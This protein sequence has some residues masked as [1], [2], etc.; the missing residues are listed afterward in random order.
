MHGFNDFLVRLDG[1]LG[2]H[3]WFMVLLI[4]TGLFFTFYLGFPQIRYFRHAL[5]ITRGKYDHSHDVGDTSHF[6]SLA[7]ALSGTVGT[8]NI[9]GV[10]LAI[11]LGGPAALFWMLITAAIGMCT[12]MVEVSLSHKYRDI[13]PDGSVSGGPMY[14]MKK[15]LNITT[16]SGKIIRT[17]AILGAFFAG[18]TV[19][20]SFGT[21]SL[22]QINSISNSVFTTFGV[23]HIITGAILAVFLGLV[24]IGGIKRIA[25]VTSVMVPFMAILYL[26]GSLLVIFSHPGNIIPSFVSIFADAFT[27]SAA[28]GGFLGATFAFAMNRGVNRGLFSNESGQGSAPIAHSAARAPEPVSEGMVSLLEPFIDTICICTLTGLVVLASGAWNTKTDNQFQATDMQILT[29]IYDD[30]NSADVE[31][32]S[33][34]L[35]GDQ[36]LDLY[37]GKLTV[38]NGVITTTGISVIHARSLASNIRFMSDKAPFSGELEVLAGKLPNMASMTV[39]GESLIHSAPLTTFAF[40]RSIMKGFGPYIVTLSL[41]L[42]AFSTAISWSYYGDRAVTYL[43][44]PKYVLYYRLIFVVAFFIASFTDTTIIWS[45]SYVAIVLMAVPNLIGILILRKEV[46][47]SV[48]DYWLTFS[49][50]Y[51]NEKISGKMSKRFGG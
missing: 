29:G 12:K 20:S 43:F 40:S 27:G 10:A 1:Y 49:K 9:A 33:S 47:Q 39:R 23:K 42:F 15:R 2:G 17:G 19:L 13:L 26:I 5:R 41:L 3:P 14:Y 50:Q 16:K 25:K 51:P 11:H 8:G 6:Q 28:A 46:K 22:P 38:E 18:A 31:K 44:G 37:N 24:I 34:H 21:G 35:R 30:G 32:L 36:F 48:K 45:L 7:T 4:G